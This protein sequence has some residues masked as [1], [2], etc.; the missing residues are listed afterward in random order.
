M[1]VYVPALQPVFATETLTPGQLSL[2]LAASTLGFAA[3][4]LEKWVLRRRDRARRV[5]GEAG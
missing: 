3:V 5:V 4:E 2:V 1:L